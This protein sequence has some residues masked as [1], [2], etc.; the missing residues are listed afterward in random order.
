[1]GGNTGW[2]TKSVP[3]P[4]PV[5]QWE[6]G[7]GGIIRV[8]HLLK[9][10]LTIAYNNQ[11][12]GTREL[13][14]DPDLDATSLVCNAVVHYPALLQLNPFVQLMEEPKAMQQLSNI[15]QKIWSGE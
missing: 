7:N 14:G 15:L 9:G 13:V 10:V 1:L 8:Y 4:Q 2:A 5:F 11:A 12:Y 3:Q 6:V